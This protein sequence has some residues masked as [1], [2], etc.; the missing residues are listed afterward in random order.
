MGCKPQSRTTV[1]G[2]KPRSRLQRSGGARVPGARP[3]TAATLALAGVLAALPLVFGACSGTPPTAAAAHDQ[4]APGVTYSADLDGDAQ[5]ERI[6]VDGGS[7]TITDGD[8]VYHS[9]DKWHVVTAALGD[10]DG[11]GL[12]E[13]VTLLDD[14]EGR[15]IGLFAYFGGQY[16]ERLVT[17]ELTARPLTLN[18]VAAPSA[19]D[20]LELTTEPRA[21]QGPPGT[22]TYRW[23]GFGFTSIQK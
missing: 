23:N 10:A 5:P 21:G 3:L 14:T 8:V 19:G 16:R 17:S 13:V 11:D 1:T 7:L 12:L 2:R 20:L 4:L 6:L 9:R 22:I 15:H 18:V